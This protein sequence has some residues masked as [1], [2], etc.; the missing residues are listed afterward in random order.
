MLSLP[1]LILLEKFTV[2]L[3]GK[4]NGR[5]KWLKAMRSHSRYQRRRAKTAEREDLKRLLLNK[6][7]CTAYST[8]KAITFCGLSFVFIDIWKRRD[9]WG[10]LF[11][12]RCY[13]PVLAAIL[14]A[15]PLWI[16]VVAATISQIKSC[17]IK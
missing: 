17:M 10:F 5:R 8:F 9:R 6:H 15:A 1:V 7:Q 2:S 16:E 12:S 13:L 11:N 4:K 14:E 3:N